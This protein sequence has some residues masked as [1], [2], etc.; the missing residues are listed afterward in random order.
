M[1]TDL[2]LVIGIIVGVLAI[3]GIL[4]AI[5]DS[6]P[7]RVAAIAVIVS[8]GLMVYAVYNKPGGYSVSDLPDVFTSVVRQFIR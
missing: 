4:S 5:I 8:G 2:A 6:N 7:P 1:S 3:P